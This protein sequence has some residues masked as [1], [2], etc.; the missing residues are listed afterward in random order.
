M[1][2]YGQA[3][4]PAHGAEGMAPAYVTQVWNPHVTT[5]GCA[6]DGDSQIS[7]CRLRPLNP[8]IG[9]RVPLFFCDPRVP[10]VI[11]A[12]SLMIAGPDG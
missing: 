11:I 4:A 12:R 1:L 6:A 8:P 2:R 9:V 5:Y 7:E 10:P 3:V